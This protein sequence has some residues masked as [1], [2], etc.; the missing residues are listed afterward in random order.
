VVVTCYG[1][2]SEIVIPEKSGLI[3]N[4]N[5]HEGFGAAL[6]RVVTNADFWETLS[7]GGIRRVQDAF[8]W[9]A[10]ANSVLRLANIYSYWNFLDIMNRQALDRYIHTLYHTIYRPRAQQLL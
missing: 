8:T 9:S 4:P 1:G 2:P 10:H 3:E 7:K 6:E 5:N